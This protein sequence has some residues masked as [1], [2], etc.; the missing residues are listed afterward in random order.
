V[1]D[2]KIIHSA[3]TWLILVLLMV[4]VEYQLS[5]CCRSGGASGSCT[6][7]E[8]EVLEARALFG[9]CAVPVSRASGR[10]KDSREHR[11]W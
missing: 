9:I 6:F 3:L 4:E 7:R 11:V 8:S 5:C 1:K 10:S 2:C